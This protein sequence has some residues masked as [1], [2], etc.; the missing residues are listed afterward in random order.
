MLRGIPLNQSLGLV[1]WSLKNSS[2]LHGITTRLIKARIFTPNIIFLNVVPLT[3]NKIVICGLN[4]LILILNV[5][6]T[7]FSKDCILLNLYLFF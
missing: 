3:M 7:E 1:I 4:F 2:S 6:T 5:E